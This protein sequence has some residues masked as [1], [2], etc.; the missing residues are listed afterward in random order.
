MK[1][2]H[3]IGDSNFSSVAESLEAIAGKKP[4]FKLVYTRSSSHASTSAAFDD[5]TSEDPIVFV[6]LSLNEMAKHM[7]KDSEDWKITLSQDLEAFQQLKLAKTSGKILLVHPFPRPGSQVQQAMDSII[8]A[9]KDNIDVSDVLKCNITDKDIALDKVHLTKQAI[10][11][12]MRSFLA[13]IRLSTKQ[14]QEMGTSQTPARSTKKRKPIPRELM[15]NSDSEQ[16]EEDNAKKAKEETPEEMI[17][18]IYNNMNKQTKRDKTVDSELNSL[19]LVT[20]EMKEAIDDVENQKSRHILMIKGLKEI[21]KAK[22][23]IPKEFAEQLCDKLKHSKRTIEYATAFKIGGERGDRQV[24]KIAFNTT[25]SAE[26]FKKIYIEASKTGKYDLKGSSISHQ[27]TNATR[28]RAQVLWQLAEALKETGEEAW[29]NPHLSTPILLVKTKEGRR[30]IKSYKY[31]EALKKFA[32]VLR[33]TDMKNP[34]Q[35]A[36]NMFPDTKKQLFLIL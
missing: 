22:N 5:I 36:D 8:Q 26:K 32:D 33:T 16:D 15:A 29:T 30:K 12:V 2:V 1:E 11:K 7:S 28:V 31:S 25:E 34:K 6:G 10:G 35:M 13:E 23:F 9:V 27:V 18:A 14:D 21:G 20:V 4:G 3:V 24:L 19:A 17:R